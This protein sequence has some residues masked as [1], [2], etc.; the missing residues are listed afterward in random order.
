[1]AGTLH[2]SKTPVLT[3]HATYAAGDYVGTS[4][5]PMDFPSLVQDS[6]D[7]GVLICAALIDAAL[8]SASVELWLFSGPVTVPA[9]SAAWT[10]SDA[11]LAAYFLGIIPFSTYYASAANSVAFV[12]GL[13]MGVW[14]FSQDTIYG[15][16]VNRAAAPAWASGDLTVSLTVLAD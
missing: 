4:A 1:M 2:V 15:A 16:L 11:D 13:T 10:V 7:T 5:V 14:S 9:D 6:A 8:Q 12:S 3:V